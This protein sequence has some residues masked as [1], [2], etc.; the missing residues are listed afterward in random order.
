MKRLLLLLVTAVAALTAHAQEDYFGQQLVIHQT[1]GDSLLT[2]LAETGLAPR[3]VDGEVV[4]YVDISSD[5]PYGVKDVES[6]DFLTPEQSLARAREGLMEFYRASDGDNWANNTNWGSD[7]PISEWAGVITYDRPYVHTLNL[8]NNNLKGELPSRGAFAKMGPTAQY[9]LFEN[10]LSGTIPEDWTRNMSLWGILIDSNQM[11]GELS[12]EF[13][14]HPSFGRLELSGNNFTG[15]MPAGMARLMD[16]PNM[17][18]IC[19]NDFSG[20]VP[21]EILDHPRFNLCW[22]MIIPQQ[23][24]LNVP[25]IPGYRFPVIDLNGNQIQ[26]TDIYASNLYTLIYNNSTSQDEFTSKLKLA[27]EA[28]KSKGFEVLGMTPGNAESVNEFMHENGITW[29][30]LDPESFGNYIGR[31]YLYLNYINLVDRDGNVVFSSI[32]DETGKMEDTGF[33]G[34]TRDQKVFDVLAEK[35]GSVDFTPYASTDYSRDGEVVTLQKATVGKGVDIVFVGNCFVDKDME[36]GG[37]YEQKMQQAMEQFFAYEPY[38]SLRERFNVYAVKAVSQNAEMYEGCKQAITSDA[39]AFAYAQKISTLIPDRPMRVNIVYNVLNAGR[40]VTFMYD[41]NSFTAFMLNGINKVLN[42][43]G[44]GHGVGRL[45]D[46]YVEEANSTAS[47]AVKDY[48]EQMWSENGRGA[49]ID[50]HADVSQTRWARFAA[51]PRYADE[52][53]GAYEGA[54]TMQYGIYRP[55]Q[56]SM[57]RFNDSPFNAPSREAIYKYVMQE[58]EGPSWTYDYETFVTF[59]AKGRAEFADAMKKA[60]KRLKKAEAADRHDVDKAEPTANEQHLPLPPVL[61]RGTWRDALAN[62]TTIKKQ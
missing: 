58:S 48:C 59:D 17:L 28:Y 49:N 37:K 12:A 30:N 42:H 38:T 19:G 39:D 52:E 45:Y 46:E 35:F 56:N 31:Y 47:D 57:M 43:E 33:M 34:S 50:M 32:M 22:D 10:Q 29:L 27:Y 5:K 44:G 1:S 16:N 26:T 4:W 24:H 11:C 2:E 8:G 55:T 14:E 13:F 60:Q 54:G 21:Q 25:T 18:H 6:I 7:K 36:P 3:L 9:N 62:P 53:L 23:G 40:S 15:S 20:N 41:D 61:K 51:D